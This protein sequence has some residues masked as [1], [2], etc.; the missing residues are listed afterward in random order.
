MFA[1][2]LAIFLTEGFQSLRGH[3]TQGIYDI[4]LSRNPSVVATQG[5]LEADVP[6]LRLVLR[7][8][9]RVRCALCVFVLCKPLSSFRRTMRRRF[10]RTAMGKSLLALTIAARLTPSS[11][12]SSSSSLSNGS[13]LHP[14]FIAPATS[15]LG[16]AD[17][18]PSTSAAK[19]SP[20]R[21]RRR[22]R[23]T[24]QGCRT[25]STAGTSPPNNCRA[26]AR[27]FSSSSNN[28]SS[29]TSSSSD[30]SNSSNSNSNS[31]SINGST[32]SLGKSGL[33]AGNTSSNGAVS[34]GRGSP[35]REPEGPAAYP[36]FPPL[37]YDQLPEES[38][39]LLDG[40]SMLFRAFYGRGAGG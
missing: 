31:N 23:P 28:N 37:T 12:S 26:K 34:T 27:R 39:Y 15:A 17:H 36:S 25:S 29:S 18:K 19:A 11:S 20:A 40:T 10:T 33:A 30:N 1:A 14:F 5:R 16:L 6:T 35:Q 38:I 22:T 32:R 24:W 8:G 21:A 3:I 4:P 9:L 13:S 2:E 7:C